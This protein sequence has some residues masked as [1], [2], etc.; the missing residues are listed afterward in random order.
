L[1]TIAAQKST[2]RVKCFSMP[3][4]VDGEGRVDTLREFR[5]NIAQAGVEDTVIPIVAGTQQAQSH[6]AAHARHGLY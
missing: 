1:I 3:D 6:L 5:R 4:L 2:N